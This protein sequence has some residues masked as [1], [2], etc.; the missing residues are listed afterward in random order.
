MN[1]VRWWESTRGR[2]TYDDVRERMIF[3][4]RVV[5]V[6][7]YHAVHIELIV[8]YRLHVSVGQS[9]GQV[10]CIPSPSKVSSSNGVQC[11]ED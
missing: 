4:P 6:F 10:R 11:T 2:R 5:V 9:V 8:A 7:A 1:D 3:F